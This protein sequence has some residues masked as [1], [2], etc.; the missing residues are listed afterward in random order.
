MYPQSAV[1]LRQ[2]FST[3]PGDQKAKIT[4][5]PEAFFLDVLLQT[6]HDLTICQRFSH[7]LASSVVIVAE[8]QRGTAGIVRQLGTRYPAL[9]LITSNR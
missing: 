1:N 4:H 5:H 2:F 9:V 3:Y 6:R 7:L 8:A